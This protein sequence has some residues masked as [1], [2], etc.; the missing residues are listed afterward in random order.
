MYRIDGKA[1]EEIK[2]QFGSGLGEGI[3]ESQSL[4]GVGL[5]NALQLPKED[6][7]VLCGYFEHPRRV[8]F[9]GCVTEPLRDHHAHLATVKLELLASAYH[10]ARCAE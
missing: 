5:G 10:I 8:Q 7:A 2:G 9:E 4:C 3:R 1:K 6:I